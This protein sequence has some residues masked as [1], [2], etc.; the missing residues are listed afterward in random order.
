MK[1]LCWTSYQGAN[2]S[3]CLRDNAQLLQAKSRDFSVLG[4]VCIMLIAIQGF[5]TAD[6]TTD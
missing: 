2:P 1:L 3:C 5:S 6:V 4:G